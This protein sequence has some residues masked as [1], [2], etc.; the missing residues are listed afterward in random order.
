[1]GISGDQSIYDLDEGFPLVTTK[2]VPYRLPFEELF[3]KL[4]G[5]RSAKS[6]FDKN[7]NIWNGNAFD[8]YLRNSGLEDKFPKHSQEWL[9]EFENFKERMKKGEIDGDLGPVYGHQWRHWKDSENK[10]IDQLENVLKGIKKKPG[11][12]YHVMSAWNVG[13]LSDM[14]IGP[15]PTIHQF[16]VFGENL[17][18]NVYQ[19]SCDV[20]LGVSL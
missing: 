7:I 13:D 14:A 17:D 15:C 9:D 5:E 3:W 18:L 4:R 10:E 1:M 6:L 12:R 20:F 19:R 8:R 2:N 11:S 16:N